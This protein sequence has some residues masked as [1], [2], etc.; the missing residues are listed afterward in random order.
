ME[1]ENTVTRKFAFLDEDED[2]HRCSFAI[3]KQNSFLFRE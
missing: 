1:M 3:E 2:D